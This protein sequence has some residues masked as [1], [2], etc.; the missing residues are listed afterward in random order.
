MNANIEKIKKLLRLARDKSASPA[1][2]ATAMSKALEMAATAGIDLSKVPTDAH[3]SSLT[4]RTTKAPWGSAERHAAVLVCKHFSVQALFSEIDGR[5]VVHFY[6]RV[7]A[8]D[9]AIYVFVY[10]VRCART[11]W[12]NRANKRL[13]N[14]ASFIYGFFLGIDE[15]LPAKFHQPGLLPAFKAYRDEFLLRGEKLVNKTITLKKAPVKALS[16]GYHAGR[17]TSIHQAIR[18]NNPLLS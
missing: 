6:G 10:I 7:D 17:K 5:K 3:S 18:G 4:H 16:A 15:L 9:L 13:K 11:A 8:C 12:K 1:E 14:R 2:A